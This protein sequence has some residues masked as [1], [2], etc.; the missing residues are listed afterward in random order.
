M[1]ENTWTWISLFS[2]LFFTDIVDENR[3][4]EAFVQESCLGTINDFLKENESDAAQTQKETVV[5]LGKYVPI[6]LQPACP[7]CQKDSIH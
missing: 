2:S 3:E 5:G 1:F 7:T 6:W 4:A